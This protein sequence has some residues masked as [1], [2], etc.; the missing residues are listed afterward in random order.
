MTIPP[1]ILAIDKNPHRLEEAHHEF[2]AVR[3]AYEVLSDPQERAWYDRHRT[4]ILS[5]DR[6]RAAADADAAPSLDDLLKFFNEGVY[7]GYGDGPRGFFTVY[8][9]LFQFLEEFEADEEMAMAGR[10]RAPSTL[11]N[12]RPA[13]TSFGSRASPYEPMV[14]QFYDKWLHFVSARTFDEADRY[15]PTWGENRRLRRAMHKENVKERDRL[16]REFSDTV[17]ELAAF[18]RK[19]DPRYAEYQRQ[20]SEQR[21]REEAERKAR[22][23]ARREEEAAS[24]VEPDWSRLDDEQLERIYLHEH[25]LSEGEAESEDEGEDDRDDT[26]PEDDDRPTGARPGDETN[27]RPNDV[28]TR[29]FDDADLAYTEFY[30]AA[31]KKLFKNHGQWKNHAKSK[32]H[33]AR[34]HSMG[35]FEVEEGES[36]EEGPEAATNARGD[37]EQAGNSC[38]IDPM[39][40]HDRD[41][42]EETMAE[43]LHGGLQRL[44]LDATDGT[45]QAGASVP[46]PPQPRTRTK[47][48][49]RRAKEDP[50]QSVSPSHA[51]LAC[52]ATFDTRNA[53]FRHLEESAHAAP[54]TGRGSKGGRR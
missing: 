31:C 16:R 33:R 12:G 48:K 52:K 51:C 32:K 41:R 44:R 20:R 42:T 49:R 7:E 39:D 10:G 25:G 18:V 53:L 35:I 26:G 1:C 30:C 19:R 50:D 28:S 24:Y 46:A 54:I 22:E 40:S 11:V 34:L 5:R 17:R 36:E 3:A 14:H 2:A 6:R 45:G 8:R 23:R 43:L 4:A 15:Q 38:R 21:A 47:K 13:Y 9:G 27:A 29:H 37:G